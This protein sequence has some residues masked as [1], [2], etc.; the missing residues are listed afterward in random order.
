MERNNT[1]PEKKREAKF[2]KYTSI[3]VILLLIVFFAARDLWFLE[4][5]AKD[6]GNC[7]DVF[8]ITFGPDCDCDDPSRNPDRD[9]DED[10]EPADSDNDNDNDYE[11]NDEYEPPYSVD[12]F[13]EE[14]HYSVETP[15]DIFSKS[16]SH[17]VNGKIAPGLTNVYEF[18]VKNNNGYSINYE[19]E[20]TE[21]ND[22]YI[23]MQFKLKLNG[24][25]I[26][27][28]KDRWVTF[29]ELKSQTKKLKAYKQDNYTLE[30]K[31]IEASND[32]DI[33]KDLKANYE[34]KLKIYAYK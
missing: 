14:T 21:R 20:M 26:A 12:V 22:D 17:V 33:G 7:V 24:N 13:D 27:G 16:T 31:W 15:L 3:I 32:T 30:W 23:N 34:L 25:Y 9:G 19:L 28:S 5:K 1:I 11:D 2:L 6:N 29:E 10:D 8:N 18:A 4:H